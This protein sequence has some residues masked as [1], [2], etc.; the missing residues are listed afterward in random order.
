MYPKHQYR[1]QKD[2]DHVFVENIS[3]VFI[4]GVWDAHEPPDR[5]IRERVREL[6]TKVAL[7]TESCGTFILEGP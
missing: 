3:L 5:V 2:Q 4:Y 1:T 6:E 7:M